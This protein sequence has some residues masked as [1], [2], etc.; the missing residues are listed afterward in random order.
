MDARRRRRLL[1]HLLVPVLGCLLMSGA[2]LRRPRGD[3]ERPNVLVILVDDLGYGDLTCYGAP[4]LRTPNI[5]ALIASGMRFDRFYANCPVCSPTR[6]SVMTGRYPDLVGVPG[7]IRTHPENSWGYL[8][9]SAVL[10]P[11]ALKPAGYHSGIVGKWHLGLESPNTPTER[12]FDEFH[13]FLGDMMDDYVTHRR[14]DINY[15]RRGTVE[16]DPKGHATDIFTDWA[17]DFLDRRKGQEEP[18]FLYLAYNA[19]H[20]PIQPPADWLARVK[21]REPGIDETRAKLVALIEHLDAGIG[22]VLDALEANGQLADTLVIFTSDNGGQLDLGARCDPL[23]GGKQDMYEGGI[24]VPMGASWAGHIESGSRSDRIALTMD[25]L[26][27]ICE[28]AGAEAPEGI[29]GRSLVDTLV[30]GE[31][32]QDDEEFFFWVRREGGR[33]YA[34]QDYYAVRQG[35]WKLFQNHPFEPYRLVDLEADPTEQVDVSEENPKVFNSLA[36]HLQAHIQRAGRVPWQG[37]D[38]E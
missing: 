6:S 31:D 17:I 18:F 2:H 22:R 10:L 1:I 24:R 4:D 36:R 23:R 20:A 28:V 25:L 14:H 30:E 33:R 34:G 11:A 35:R 21:R 7:V 13:G 38:G 26:P 9:P 37:P 15:M 5:D 8:D 16:V 32:G 27:T 12:G 3:G 19:P 29:D